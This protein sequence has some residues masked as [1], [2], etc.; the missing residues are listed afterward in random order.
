MRSN[1]NWNFY[2][3]DNVAG[4]TRHE[5][6]AIVTQLQPAWNSIGVQTINVDLILSGHDLRPKRRLRR[7]RE[8]P[9]RSP[10]NPLGFNLGSEAFIH[11]VLF[12]QGTGSVCG[13]REALIHKNG[14]L[15]LSKFKTGPIVGTRKPYVLDDRC[16]C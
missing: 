2:D 6:L 13:T 8:T 7:P 15:Y 1:L 16:L 4:Q 12:I 5:K 10:Q 3:L 14:D 11:D 9:V